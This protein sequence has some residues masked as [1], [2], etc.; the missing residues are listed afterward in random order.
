MKRLSEESIV[1][2]LYGIDMGVGDHVC[3]RCKKRFPKLVSLR[4]HKK[5]CT[6]DASLRPFKTSRFSRHKRKID[7]S[8]RLSGEAAGAVR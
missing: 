1:N 4:Y 3:P 7:E 5:E 6:G 8:Q 2:A